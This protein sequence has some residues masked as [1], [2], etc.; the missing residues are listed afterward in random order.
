MEIDDCVRDIIK[1]I[2]VATEIR[3]DNLL[4]KPV[5]YSDNSSAVK[6]TNRPKIRAAAF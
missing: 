3:L 4:D 6:L 5:L 1:L 2:N